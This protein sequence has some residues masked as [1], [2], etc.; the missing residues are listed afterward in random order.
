MTMATTT[1]KRAEFRY[2]AE[3][4]AAMGLY[5]VLLVSRPFLLAHLSGEAVQ[6]TIKMLPVL[7]LWLTIWVVVRHYRRI[8]E[9]ARLRLLMA[10]SLAFG[11]GSCLLMTGVF[12]KD[13]GFPPLDL[14]WA[15]PVLGVSWAVASI[16]LAIQDR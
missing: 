8:D 12:L 13:V 10:I 6:D 15:W 7:P 11:I 16:V 4:A 9:Y 2:M 5:V 1:P 14:T 3:M